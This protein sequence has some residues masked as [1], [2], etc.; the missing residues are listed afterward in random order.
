MLWASSRPFLVARN[1]E[2]KEYTRSERTQCT[3]IIPFHP[4]NSGSNE[5]LLSFS[6]SPC[7]FVDSNALF[8]MQF[9]VASGA[10]FISTLR[11][12][13]ER[14][15][16]RSILPRTN[17]LS[18]FPSF[19]AVKYT[20]CAV[21]ARLIIFEKSHTDDGRNVL[22]QVLEAS[23]YRSFQEDESLSWYLVSTGRNAY[24]SD[25]Y[26]RKER[27]RNQLEKILTKLFMIYLTN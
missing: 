20:L 25:C 15:Q 1:S 3:C 10:S 23:T 11:M 4:F 22:A 19:P 14:V 7:V 2:E 6:F 17:S 8:F 24:F 16:L 26:I 5:S 18:R 13:A 21:S 27:R 9:L 12:C